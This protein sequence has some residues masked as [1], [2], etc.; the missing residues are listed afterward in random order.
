[1]LSVTSNLEVVSDERT[2]Q[3]SD[4]DLQLPCPASA[5]G[6]Q[7]C[8]SN[9]SQRR[10]LIFATSLGNGTTQVEAMLADPRNQE[11]TAAWQQRLRHDGYMYTCVRFFVSVRDLA[12]DAV[13]LQCRKPSLLSITSY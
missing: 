10:I 4:M 11:S 2:P 5:H 3:S 8:P 12:T 7:N 13:F 6:R 9:Q 1:M